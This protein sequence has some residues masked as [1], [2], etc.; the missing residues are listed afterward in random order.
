MKVSLSIDV[1]RMPLLEL[2]IKRRKKK[3]CCVKIKRKKNVL[4]A[5][6][7]KSQWQWLERMSETLHRLQHSVKAG[8]VKE[9]LF[10]LAVLKNNE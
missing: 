2:S 3:Q 4:S 10:A 7:H 1:P 9:R 8:T 6:C 5:P